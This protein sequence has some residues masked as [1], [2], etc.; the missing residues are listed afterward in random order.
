MAS[1]ETPEEV[2]VHAEQTGKG[3]IT[4]AL[5]DLNSDGVARTTEPLS[6]THPDS[7]YGMLVPRVQ[8]MELSSSLM[9]GRQ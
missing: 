8:E 1:S 9:E 4:S 6:A 3:F 2:A 7:I 5:R